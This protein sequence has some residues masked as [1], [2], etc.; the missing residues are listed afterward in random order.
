MFC[1][2]YFECQKAWSTAYSLQ[3]TATLTLYFQRIVF[4]QIITL[5]S[6]DYIIKKM[7][8]DPWNWETPA[9]SEV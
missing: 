1:D 3:I 2:Q 7:F 5:I 9:Y 6:K 8:V 4:T